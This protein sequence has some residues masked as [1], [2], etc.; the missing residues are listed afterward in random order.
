MLIIGVVNGGIDRGAAITALT[1]LALTLGAGGVTFWHTGRS[2][3]LKPS[4]PLRLPPAWVL[5]GL[6]GLALV[7][8]MAATAIRRVEVL[9][10]PDAFLVAAALPPLWAVAWFASGS[11]PQHTRALTRRRGLVAFAGGATA[12]VA[13]AMILSIL[14]PALILSLVVDLASTA[15]DA[16]DGLLTS[17]AGSR[18]AEAITGP[19][20]LYAMVQLAIVAPL[21]EELAKPLIT[22]PLARRMDKTG[23]FLVGAIAGAGFA[24]LE[25]VLYAGFGLRFWAGILLI[26]AIGGAIHPLGSGLMA[27]GWRAVLRGEPGAG[28]AWLGRFGMAA[29]VHALWNGGSLL[30]ITLAGARFFGELPPEI[31]VLGL[32]A[33]GATLALLIIL[34]LGALWLGRATVAGMDEAGAPVAQPFVLSDR[35]VALWA[36]A[37]LLALVPAGITGLKLILGG[38]S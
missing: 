9:L 36:V 38:G 21:A 32:S 3:S 10:F 35:A 7:V 25:N 11:P 1:L 6:F 5:A 22:L 13:L 33:A 16:V 18:V 4:S 28:R 29:G 2:R 19:G 23:A 20:F 27:L 14:T 8:A 24:A 30:V 31:D 15:L 17:L 34:G 12:S 26:R 37:C